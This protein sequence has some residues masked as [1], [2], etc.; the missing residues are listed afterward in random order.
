VASLAKI[1]RRVFCH[2]S[3]VY[4]PIQGGIPDKYGEPQYGPPLE[5]VCRWE[6]KPQEIILP[7]GR[8]VHAKG[9]ILLV[10]Q[11]IAGSLAY[12]GTLA[13]LQQLYGNTNPITVTQGGREVLLVKT[14][15]DVKNK[16]V[17]YEAWL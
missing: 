9:Y 7:H 6:D 2:Q 8:K 12:L 11:L 5:L 14:T 10:D 15:P 1:V 3:L 4:W 16:S 13:Q 17:I